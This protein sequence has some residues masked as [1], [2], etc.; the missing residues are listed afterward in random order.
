MIKIIK[1]GLNT[2]IQDK[3]RIGYKNIGV[4][5]SG[6][7]D[8]EAAHLAN[9]LVNNP[10][11]FPLLEMCLLGCSFK[12]LQPLTI[13]ITG[14]DMQAKINNVNT[15]LNTTICLKKNDI[16]TFSSTINGVYT[17]IAFS[18]YLISP[19]DLGSYAMYSKANLGHSPLKKGDIIK[20]IKSKEINLNSKVKQKTYSN[21]IT[22]TCLKGPEFDLFSK[23]SIDVFFSNTYTISTLSNRMGIRL[24]GRE[25]STPQK[26]EIISS[27]IVK[28]TV[29]ITKKGLPIVMMADAPTT[30][31]YLRLINLTEKSCNLLAQVAVNGVVKFNLKK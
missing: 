29:Q 20:I 26:K 19:I 22:L 4:P 27:G 31:G 13:A 28:G 5:Q 17:Y 12:T 16:V 21:C 10:I 15:T 2:T 3:G 30:G 9:S 24:E 6:F 7:M 8:T 18:G 11:T 14:A 1:T 25:V 23:K